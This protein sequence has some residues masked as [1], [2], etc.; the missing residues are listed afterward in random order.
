MHLVF[1][2]SNKIIDGNIMQDHTSKIIIL[3]S[4]F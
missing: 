1:N 2:C 3:Q 4:D